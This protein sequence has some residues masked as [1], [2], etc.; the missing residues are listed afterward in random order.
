MK[1]QNSVIWPTFIVRRKRHN[2]VTGEKYS[3]EDTYERVM[4]SST[5]LQ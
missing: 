5:D 4:I 2:G 3:R 1:R